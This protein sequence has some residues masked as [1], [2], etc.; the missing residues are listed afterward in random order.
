M[1]FPLWVNFSDFM[2]K[3]KKK[4]PA[5][6]RT[7]QAM[8]T[9]YVRNRNYICVNTVQHPTDHCRSRSNIRFKL[10]QAFMVTKVGNIGTKDAT[11][12]S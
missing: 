1:T 4:Q 8:N 11:L 7:V 12:Q 2:Q 6:C 10:G 3:T 9:Y 5:T